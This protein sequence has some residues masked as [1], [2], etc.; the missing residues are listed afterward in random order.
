[1]RCQSGREPG[2]FAR[3]MDISAGAGGTSKVGYATGLPVGGCSILD[4]TGNPAACQASQ[5]PIRARALGQPACLSSCA[6]RAL[7]ASCGQAQ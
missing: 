4:S 6:T 7:V 3:M 5:P 2:G 1:M